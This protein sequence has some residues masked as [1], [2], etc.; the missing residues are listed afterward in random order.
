MELWRYLGHIARHPENG[1]LEL[2][3]FRGDGERQEEVSRD[4]ND[5]KR[6]IRR[7][8]F[9]AGKKWPNEYDFLVHRFSK[10]EGWNEPWY[11]IARDKATWYELE[12]KFCAHAAKILDDSAD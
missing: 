12:E 2:V 6:N 5:I 8:V 11:H 9:R 3:C 10:S 1:I 7:W 4:K